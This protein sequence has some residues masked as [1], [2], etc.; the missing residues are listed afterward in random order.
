MSWMLA[1]RHNKVLSVSLVA[2]ASSRHVNDFNEVALACLVATDETSTGHHMTTHQAAQAW[3][4]TQNGKDSLSR[5][6]KAR[7]GFCQSFQRHFHSTR[8][9]V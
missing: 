6:H 5:A 9:A 8:R 1:A 4:P 3:C 2:A 7:R